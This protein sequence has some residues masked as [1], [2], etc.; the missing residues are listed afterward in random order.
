MRIF[1]IKQA[2]SNFFFQL[3]MNMSK[4]KK[5]IT[6]GITATIALA[7]IAFFAV[8]TIPYFYQSWQRTRFTREDFLYDFD[9]M[10]A[11]LEVNFPSFGIIY[12]HHGVDML[13][14]AQ[15]LRARLQDS[16]KP[17]DFETFWN[18]LR[19]DFFYHAYTGYVPLP[20]GHLHMLSDSG[21]RNMIDTYSAPHLS[22]VAPYFLRIFNTPPTHPSYPYLEAHT[23]PLS[24]L[25]NW[26]VS[27]RRVL[28]IDVIEEGAIG[29]LR[30]YT[31]SRTPSSTEWDELLDFY[32]DIIDF[33]HLI[34]DLRGNTGGVSYHFYQA[35]TSYLI[36]RSLV[37]N[38]HHFLMD[39]E[40][41][42][43][44]FHNVLERDIVRLHNLFCADGHLRLFTGNDALGYVMEVMDGVNYR[45]IE[46]RRVDP[47][48]RRERRQFDGKIWLLIDEYNYSAALE[49]A[50]FHKETGFATLVGQT[51][52]GGSS[53]R[54]WG[55]NFFALPNTGIIIRYDPTLVTDVRGR[56]LEYGIE[57]H[58][59]N[60]PGMDALET[61]LAL[62]AEGNY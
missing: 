2:I 25:P 51:T 9:Y 52:R 12:R 44:F 41:N 28:S 57:P 47:R 21:R 55:S 45:I 56:P 14:V 32:N 24:N 13:E 35:A 17:I 8:F 7:V 30:F 46:H 36:D 53:G 31:F 50:H 27:R 33:E 19:D 29:Y 15:D 16:T 58:H 37:A 26:E 40:H 18:M 60:R 62:I 10:V 61:V 3:S 42:M 6:V 11:V 22:D 48:P 34:I 59:F 39:G 49:I 54:S 23:Y 4:K 5:P 20:I 38:F 43:V 1:R